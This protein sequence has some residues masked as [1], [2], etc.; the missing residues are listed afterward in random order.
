MSE[1]VPEVV[2]EIPAVLIPAQ[3]AGEGQLAVVCPDMLSLATS[4]HLLSAVLTPPAQLSRRVRAGKY[5][6]VADIY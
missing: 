5:F 4:R 3:P 6:R 1:D 2:V